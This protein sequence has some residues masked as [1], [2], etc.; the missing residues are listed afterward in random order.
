MVPFFAD[1]DGVDEGNFDHGR[2]CDSLG[3]EKAFS[4]QPV[5]LPPTRRLC[6]DLLASWSTTGA[7]FYTPPS[8]SC[9]PPPS[10]RILRVGMGAT[11]DSI[12]YVTV[13]DSTCSTLTAG[14]RGCVQ[15]TISLEQVDMGEEASNSNPPRGNIR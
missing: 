12:N 11:G 15:A 3:S 5:P 9:C 4:D 10:C 2:F 14:T 1:D 13:P 6:S 8:R 7:S